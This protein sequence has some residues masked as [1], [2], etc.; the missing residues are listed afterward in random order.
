M[1]R[2]LMGRMLK[3]LRVKGADGSN[4]LLNASKIKK[5]THLS[6]RIEEWREGQVCAKA[7]RPPVR[8]W[9]CGSGHPLQT[10]LTFSVWEL[11]SYHTGGDSMGWDGD[12]KAGLAAGQPFGGLVVK[13]EFNMLFCLPC[14]LKILHH[15][16]T[17]RVE[18]G[19]KHQAASQP[20]NLCGL[21]FH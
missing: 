9:G 17:V 15:E 10:C 18:E 19:L 21:E 1:E 11:S 4:L 12:R 3:C 8:L 5:H 2:Y 20:A 14:V 7:T 6:K 13:H 16:Q